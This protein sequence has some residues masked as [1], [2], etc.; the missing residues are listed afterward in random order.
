MSGARGSGDW[1]LGKVAHEGTVDWSPGMSR[2]PHPLDYNADGTI[3]ARIYA[4]DGSFVQF[5]LANTVEN[6]MFVRWLRRHDR[7]TPPRPAS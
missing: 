7:Y 4:Q 1:L 2:D 3:S 5:S 6:E